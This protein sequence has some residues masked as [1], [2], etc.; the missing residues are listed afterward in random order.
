MQSCC[1]K[2]AQ[3]LANLEALQKRVGVVEDVLVHARLREVRADIQKTNEGISIVQGNWEAA[4]VKLQ[5]LDSEV[6]NVRAQIQTISQE[7]NTKLNDDQAL[8]MKQTAQIEKVETTLGKIQATQHTLPI[9]MEKIQNHLMQDGDT[10]E[11]PNVE[12]MLA[13]SESIPPQTG[14][15]REIVESTVLSGSSFQA[16]L[17]KQL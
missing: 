13:V 7:L 2:A 15:S 16:D 10:D 14:P 6:E 5:G 4:T 1:T 3:T 11:T 9:I 17:E 12:E 8:L